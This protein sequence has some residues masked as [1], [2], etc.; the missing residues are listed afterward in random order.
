VNSIIKLNK[1]KKKVNFGLNEPSGI[2]SPPLVDIL[3]TSKDGS[4]EEI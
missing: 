1:E 3:E 4:K 2:G